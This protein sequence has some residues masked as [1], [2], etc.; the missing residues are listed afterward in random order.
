[1]ALNVPPTF[2]FV[3]MQFSAVNALGSKPIFTFG[4]GITPNAGTAAE[5]ETWWDQAYQPFMTSG[6]RLEEIRMTNIAEAN[7]RAVGLNGSVEG[8]ASPPATSVLVQKRTG[9]VGRQNKGRMYWPFVC[10][11]AQVDNGGNIFT[12]HL[13]DLQLAATDLYDRAEADW[14]GMF[15]FHSGSSDPTPITS[16]VVSPTLATQRRRQRR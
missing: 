6:A 1:M 7:E 12:G 13:A 8:E 11:D 14:G 10:Q 3:V 2:S 16:L 15:L 9:L 4:L 5:I